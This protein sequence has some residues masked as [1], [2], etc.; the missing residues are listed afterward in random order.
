MKLEYTYEEE[1]KIENTITDYHRM[2]EKLWRLELLPIA[3]VHDLHKF[4]EVCRLQEKQMLAMKKRY[5][6]AEECLE[7]FWKRPKITP[8]QFRAEF[9]GDK[10]LVQQMCELVKSLTVT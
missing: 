5:Q 9:E 3:K 8:S 10:K 2:Y 7:S 1:N 6:N 4:N